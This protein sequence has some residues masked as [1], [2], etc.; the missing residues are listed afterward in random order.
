MNLIRR[1]GPPLARY[2]PSSIEDQLGRMV[3]SM[4]EDFLA[5]AAHAA[6]MGRLPE[7]GLGSPRVNIA[8]DEKTFRVEAAL[9]GVKKEDVKVSVDG[10]RVTIEAEAKQEA[11][12]REGENVVY[13]E[14]IGRKFVRNFL[15]PTDDADARRENGMLTLT[16]PKK[17]AT[18]SKQLMIQ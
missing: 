12:Q 9:P 16:L 17:Q 15:V 3:E 14:R 6:A 1:T 4:I 13:A 2:H 5:P 7:Q 8:E 10:Q 18:A 11:E